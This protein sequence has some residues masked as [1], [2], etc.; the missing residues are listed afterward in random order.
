MSQPIALRLFHAGQLTHQIARESVIV[1]VVN[2]TTEASQNGRTSIDHQ[3]K[4]PTIEIRDW[5]MSVALLRAGIMDKCNQAMQLSPRHFGSSPQ[6]RVRVAR[7]VW[8][9]HRVECIRQK[10]SEKD[11]L[12]DALSEAGIYDLV[13]PSKGVVSNSG[14]DC[15]MQMMKL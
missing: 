6:E 11:T 10:K 13:P 1:Q 2:S 3:I 9:R 15:F 7:R 14:Y 12:T 4:R 8:Q 5:L